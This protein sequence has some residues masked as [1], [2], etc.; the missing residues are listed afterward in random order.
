MAFSQK[1]NDTTQAGHAISKTESE[2]SKKGKKTQIKKVSRA[3][4]SSQD[5]LRISLR[6]HHKIK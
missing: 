6:P 2:S 5:Q 4:A 3:T 1:L